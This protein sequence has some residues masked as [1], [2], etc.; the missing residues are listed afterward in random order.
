LTLREAL[1]RLETDGHRTAAVPFERLA[2]VRARYEHLVESGE[3]YPELAEEFLGFTTFGPPD[4]VPQP[5]SLVVVATRDRWVRLTFR[6]KGLDVTVPVPP[7]YL[8]L[9][10]WSRD[11]ARKLQELLPAGSR[12]VS[13]P[14]APHKLLAVAS[15]LARY[16]RNNLAYIEGFGSLHRL[17]TLCTDVPCEELEWKTPSML[18]ACG[19]CTRCI[20]ACPTG[21]VPQ[22]RFLLR[23]HLCITR[24]NE[25]PGDIPFPGWIPPDAHECIIGC[26]RCQRVCPVNVPLFGQE[27]EGP[28][29]TEEETAA[30]L[31]GG[32][33]ES[34]PGP[35]RERLEEWVLDDWLDLFPRNLGAVLARV[36]DSGNLTEPG[37]DG[38]GQANRGSEGP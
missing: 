17:T 1:A 28:V 15:G 37:A 13:L 8:R 33:A 20:E 16:G 24:W 14:N 32:T 21:A 12:V 19:S 38:S 6:W 18:E 36:T 2:D 25:M 22:D 35:L 31:Q 34:L 29:F 9:R 7:A 4:A 5:R 23:A 27:Q 26:L 10:E 3:L 11:L 30:L